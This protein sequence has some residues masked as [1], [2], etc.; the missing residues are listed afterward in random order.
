MES[1]GLKSEDNV[2]KIQMVTFCVEKENYAVSVSEV[3]EIILPIDTFPVPG[4]RDPVKGVIN[5][6]G[7]IVPVLDIH[8]ILGVPKIVKEVS[9]KNSKKKRFI[10]LD[11]EDGGVGF[12]VDRVMEVVK[13]RE[14]KIQPSPEI[15][16]AN[17]NN[18]VLLGFIQ[19]K[20]EIII[21]IDP[22]KL[23]ESCM[24]IGELGKSYSF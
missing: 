17:I 15:G 16:K 24:N 3:K 18:D 1:M 10:I 8:S 12:E 9:S 5:L 21:V 11:S 20:G 23:L 7:E 6:R 14:D 22:V 4:M 19:S 2:P 13:F